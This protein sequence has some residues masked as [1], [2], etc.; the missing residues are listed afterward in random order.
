MSQV[1]PEQ[2]RK[3]IE[4]TLLAAG[5]PIPI[6]RIVALFPADPPSR[7]EVRDALQAIEQSCEGRGFEL[8]EVASGFRFQVAHDLGPWVARLWD[9]RP[10]RY[11][12]ALL[13]TL[14]LIAYRQPVTR[15]DIEAVRGV[16]VSSNIIRTLL[17]RGWIRIV[18]HRDSPGRPS[19]YG[20]TKQFLDYFT[21]KSLDELPPLSDLK[22]LGSLNPELD[23]DQNDEDGSDTS[24]KFDDDATDSDFDDDESEDADESEDSNE[25]RSSDAERMHEPGD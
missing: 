21:L 10:P 4:G 18:G 7:A 16:S 25:D 9:E 23:F 20:T 1:P 5:E 15:G 8:Q 3:I 12:R 19:L 2:L 14:A 13:E 11:S 24:N 22:D 17:E 6:E